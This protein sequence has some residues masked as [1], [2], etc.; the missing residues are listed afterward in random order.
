MMPKIFDAEATAK[1]LPYSRLI[2]RMGELFATGISSP[3]RHHHTMS[4]VGEPDATL[5]LMPAWSNEL[6]CV[7]IVTAYP[8]NAGRGLPAIAGTVLAFDRT[9]GTHRA[10]L[11]GTVLTARRTAAA[12]ALAARALAPSNAQTLLVLGS[13]RVAAELPAAFQAIRPIDR[14]LVWSRTEASAERLVRSLETS[15]FQAIVVRDLPNAVAEAD[16]ISAATLATEPVLRGAWLRPGQ[17]IDLIGAF[18]PLMR[19]AD[20]ELLRRGRLFIDTDIALVEA[21]ELAIPLARK[22][23][24][25]VDIVGDL[26][27]LATGVAG[28]VASEEI[29]IFKSVGNAVMDLAAVLTAMEESDNYE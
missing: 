17:H 18:T 1:R 3:T 21:G 20:D 28:R 14:V 15:G 8:G 26:A 24:S 4:V 22:A 23:I 19:E 13:G 9:D 11:D 5:L 12:S 2:Q 29:T 10:F 27:A 7:K 16:I 25:T 6:G